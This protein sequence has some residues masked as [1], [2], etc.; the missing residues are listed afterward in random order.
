M[1]SYVALLF[2]K[3]RTVVAGPDLRWL[4]YVRAIVNK[5]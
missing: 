3:C 4:G 2:Y 5:A 1:N